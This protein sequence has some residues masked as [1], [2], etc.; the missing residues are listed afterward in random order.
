MSESSPDPETD[1]HGV[2]ATA[3]RLGTDARAYVHYHSAI[4]NRVWVL[5]PEGDLHVSVDIG[6]RSVWEWVAYVRHEHE[7]WDELRLRRGD[8]LAGLAADV[9][10]AVE[11]EA[12]RE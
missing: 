12:E 8:G 2:P 9:A 1:A 5:S 11:V 3:Y 10:D 7:E 6:D 4:E